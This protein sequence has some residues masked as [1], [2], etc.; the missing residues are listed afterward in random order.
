M[1]P[2]RSALT[3]AAFMVFCSGAGPDAA[4][5]AQTTEAGL[6]ADVQRLAD[7]SAARFSPVRGA[8]DGPPSDDGFQ[9][10]D[11][12]FK[13]SGADTCKVW[14]DLQDR[15]WGYDCSWHIADPASG[16]RQFKMLTEG[17]AS[18]YPYAWT[19]RPWAG[20]FLIGSPHI[21]IRF[22]DAGRLTGIVLTIE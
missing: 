5:R 16:A 17:V 10:Y 21:K 19:D 12:Q 14:A 22:R 3:L 7:M 20:R 2:P 11:A 9:Y 13:L 8:I 4:I 1:C 6:C 15:G 18:C